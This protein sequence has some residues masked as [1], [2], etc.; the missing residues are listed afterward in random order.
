MKKTSTLHDVASK[1][2]CSATAASTILNGRISSARFSADL[3]VRVRHAA[4]ALHYSP[5]LKRHAAPPVCKVG[6]V[7]HSFGEDAG[8]E[9]S[10]MR[11]LTGQLDR[12][13]YAQQ[14]LFADDK[15]H[16]NRLRNRMNR[17][18]LSAAVS[19][20]MDNSHNPGLFEMIG[21]PLVLANPY[22]LVEYNAIVP[23]EARGVDAAVSL[24]RAMG[25]RRIV[26]AGHRTEHFS[27]ELRQESLRQGCLSADIEIVAEFDQTNSSLENIRP[28]LQK[29]VDV[30]VS[31]NNV[32]ARHW[33]SLMAMT[34]VRIPADM[35]LLSLGGTF[36]GKGT[37]HI[38]HIETPFAEIGRLAGDMCVDMVA[39]RESTFNTVYVPPRLDLGQTLRAIR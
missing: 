35:G 11:E 26:Y 18:D 5:Q 37:S 30:I 39:S 8:M 34:G 2:G 33:E 12:C 21:L 7:I 36:T 9:T 16:A 6:I 15:L 4:V 10:F 25:C 17:A 23:D 14:I 20:A 28:V 19:L 31:Y 22:Q 3:A 32:V 29:K 27:G 13:G 24:L 1:A 38:T